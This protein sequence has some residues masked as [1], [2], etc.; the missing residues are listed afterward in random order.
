MGGSQSRKGSASMVKS[1]FV[2]KELVGVDRTCMEACSKVF[3]STFSSQ[4]KM[5][6]NVHVGFLLSTPKKTN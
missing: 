3:K 4:E 1:L 2:E 6:F 5:L